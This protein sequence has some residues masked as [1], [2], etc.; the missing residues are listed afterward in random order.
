MQWLS[1]ALVVLLRSTQRP[2]FLMLKPT[3]V[4]FAVAAVMF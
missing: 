1:L 3:I 2:R 4:H